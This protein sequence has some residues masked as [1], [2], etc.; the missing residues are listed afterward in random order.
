MYANYDKP[1]L[2]SIYENLAFDMK[3]IENVIQAVQN[4][5]KQIAH[6]LALIFLLTADDVGVLFVALIVIN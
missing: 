2:N 3:N 4:N 6:I 5:S 1:Y